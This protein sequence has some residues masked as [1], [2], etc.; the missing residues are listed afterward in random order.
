MIIPNHH[1]IINLIARDTTVSKAI[2]VII[3]LTNKKQMLYKQN[4]LE[5]LF[6]VKA[7]ALKQHRYQVL[8][9]QYKRTS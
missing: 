3:I 1:H 8:S 6:L 2:M 5:F 7:A 4:W 9:T